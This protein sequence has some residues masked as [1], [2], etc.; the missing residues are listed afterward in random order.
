MKYNYEPK[1]KIGD[2]I[3]KN[4]LS[5]YSWGKLQ[6]ADIQISDS[7][8]PAPYYKYFSLD[9]RNIGRI[10]ADSCEGIDLDYTLDRSYA[11][12]RLIDGL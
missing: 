2:I 6:I 1:F 11:L 7:D 9:E 8:I 12:K 5:D 3:I 4:P 10:A